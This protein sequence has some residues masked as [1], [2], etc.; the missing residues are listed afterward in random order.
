MNV[1]ILGLG[2]Y[3]QGSGV[4]AALFFA[5]PLYAVVIERKSRAEV[6]GARAHVARSPLPFIPQIRSQLLYQHRKRMAE[7]LAGFFDPVVTR[8]PLRVDV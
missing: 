6:R 4:A 3:P 7:S 1:L 8:S 5:K 2:Q